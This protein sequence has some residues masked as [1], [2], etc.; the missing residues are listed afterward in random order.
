MTQLNRKGKRL[1][2]D[3]R[4]ARLLCV[5]SSVDGVSRALGGM[6]FSGKGRPKFITDD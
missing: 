4:S 6:S 2:S 5:K 3:P 1:V